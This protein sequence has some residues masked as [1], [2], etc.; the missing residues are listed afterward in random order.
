MLDHGAFDTVRVPSSAL[1]A[2][3]RSGL[4][5]VV[6]PWHYLLRALHILS[7][8]AFFGGIMLLDLRPIGVRSAA[9]LKA[10][11]AD[12]MPCVYTVFGIATASGILLFLYDPVL[13]ASRD[14]FVPKIVLV[15]LGLVNAALYNR[16]AYEHALMAQE[17]TPL[18]A[19]FAGSLSITFW[20]GVMVFSSSPGLNFP[21]CRRSQRVR[22][23]TFQMP[24][25][26][27][28]RYR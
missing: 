15:V 7:A 18:S 13:V 24:T 20:V 21:P 19:K 5:A 12:V 10:F 8:A 1:L 14:Y 9:K 17:D 2:L 27:E 3:D 22:A 11:S 4:H 16:F 28:C 23:K 26:S 6:Q 25:T